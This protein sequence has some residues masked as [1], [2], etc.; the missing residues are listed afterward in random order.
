MLFGRK[1]K[2]ELTYKEEHN[3][4]F[5]RFQK[6]SRV[7]IWAGAISFISLV[8]SVLQA[9]QKQSA[10]FFYFCF[11]I[12]DVIFRAL[13]FIPYFQN[14]NGFVLYIVLIF[15]IS[16]I[17]TAG[18][19]LLSVYASQGKKKPL[20]AMFIIYAIDT[21]AIIGSYFLGENIISIWMM[22]GLHVI[23]L[24][25]LGIAI[26]EYY[27]VIEVAVKHGALKPKVTEGVKENGTE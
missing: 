12:D 9:L 8:V 24:A 14:N 17:T 19:V 6:A 21:L 13:T 3:K 16:I 27:K 20:W 7:M 26:Y 11:G 25:F 5:F 22:F 23:V 15:I 4:H 18:A 10:L 2:R 1:N